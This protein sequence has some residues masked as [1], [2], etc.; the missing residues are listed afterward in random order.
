MS[1]IAT[2]PL[3][4]ANELIGDLEG[5]YAL[6]SSPSR[7]IGTLFPDVTVR[8]VHDD[9]YVVT[10]FPV[11]TGTPVSDHTFAA[12]KR[13]E[14]VFGYTDDGKFPGYTRQAYADILALAATREPFDVSTGKRL[15]TN[16]VFG[17][18]S[19]VSDE[20]FESAGIFTARLQEVII[21]ETDD[22]DGS[23]SANP[24]DQ[25][26]PQST[27]PSTDM[28]IVQLQPAPSAMLYADYEAK[29]SGGPSNSDAPL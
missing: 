21:S 18:I 10:A 4:V 14:I 9:E 7:Y 8:E 3:N 1:L 25:A 26:E 17:N 12:P 15:Y 20:Q 11:E 16:M 24:Q 29:F 5:N 13:I 28:G 6:I 22:G 23:L 2:T 19:A 27:A